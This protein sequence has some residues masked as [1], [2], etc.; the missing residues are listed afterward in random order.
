MANSVLLK[1]IANEVETLISQNPKAVER[2]REQ[3]KV[4]N[5]AWRKY[6]TAQDNYAELRQE[7]WNKNNIK[8]F[9][10]E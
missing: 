1:R 4:F 10:V 9:C 2:F 7:K 5:D 3:L 6:W 8:I